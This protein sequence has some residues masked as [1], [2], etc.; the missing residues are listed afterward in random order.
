MKVLFAQQNYDKL[1]AYRVLTT[2]EQAGDDVRVYKRACS[3]AATAYVRGL[4]DKQRLLED[5]VGERAAVVAGR[6]EQ[7]GRVSYPFVRLPTVQSLICEQVLQDDYA[8]AYAH[9][10]RWMDWIG[11]LATVETAADQNDAL[12]EIYGDCLPHE[13]TT[14]CSDHGRQGGV[15]A[16]GGDES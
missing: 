16:D 1:P 5:F 13:P 12:I 6:L 14:G 10:R 15:D 3:P 2:I 8:A 9:L 4:L 11:A 7:D